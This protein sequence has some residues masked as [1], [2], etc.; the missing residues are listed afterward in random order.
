MNVNNRFSL[1]VCKITTKLNT[2]LWKKINTVFQIYSPTG[3]APLNIML[4]FWRS[5]L[6]TT[7]LLSKLMPFCCPHSTQT[8]GVFIKS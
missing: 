1:K 6:I 7:A 3:I 2:A 4:L 8:K 5:V